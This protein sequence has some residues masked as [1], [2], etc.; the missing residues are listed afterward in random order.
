M[1]FRSKTK[2]DSGEALFDGNI[3]LTELDETEIAELGIGRKFQKPTVFDNHTVEDNLLLALK[4]PRGVFATLFGAPSRAQAA[5]MDN[6]LDIVHLGDQRLLRATQLSHGQSNGWR[7]A[8]CWP[9]TPNC[10]W[11]TSPPPA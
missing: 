1:L 10:C 2:P 5:R 9:R 3:D 8:C 11:S 7:S 4:A 6:L